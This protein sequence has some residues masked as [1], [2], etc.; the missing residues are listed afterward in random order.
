M[1]RLMQAVFV[2]SIVLS[3]AAAAPAA[4]P[5]TAKAKS[6]DDKRAAKPESAPCRSCRFDCPA[7]TTNC[8]ACG[9]RLPESR[10]TKKLSPIET[11]VVSVLPD[12][13]EGRAGA[14]ASP[15]A[16]YEEAE[17]WITKH[18]DEYD[19]AIRRLEQLTEKVRGTALESLVQ[20][21]VY[22][23]SAEKKKATRH[24]TV[25]EREAETAEG[26]QKVMG[27]IMANPRNHSEN[28]L[29]LKKLL[30]LAHGTSYEKYV[31]GMLR[32]EEAKVGR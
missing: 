2:L 24:R 4:E 18:P 11:L 29:A 17:L 6:K 32:R 13:R 25:K 3:L 21:R 28:I 7:D 9:T 5:G 27:M 19:G 31:R 26:V 10:L 15:E 23:I 1:K 12:E 14:P 30:R 8:W 20:K 22:E 16:A